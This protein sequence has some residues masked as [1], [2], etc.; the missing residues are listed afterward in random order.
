MKSKTL[1]DLDKA[2]VDVY[3]A[4]DNMLQVFKE[5]KP[6]DYTKCTFVA[7]YFNPANPDTYKMMHIGALYDVLAKGGI[8]MLQE[9]LYMPTPQE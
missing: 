5:L 6:E 4:T 1:K 8:S 3:K 2:F 9:K 7:F